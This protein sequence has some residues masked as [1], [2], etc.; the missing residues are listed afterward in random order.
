MNDST[1]Q[2]NQ[3]LKQMLEEATAA[4]AAVPCATNSQEGDTETTSLRE[5]WLAFGQL[6]RVADASLPAMPDIAA[7][8]APQKSRRSRWSRSWWI[9]LVAATAAALLIAVTVGWWSHRDRGAGIQPAAR[10]SVAASPTPTVPVKQERPTTAVSRAEQATNEQAKT[11]P[12]VTFNTV[13]SHTAT[14]KPATSTWEEDPLETQI[15]S[16]SE[17]IRNVEENWRHRVDDADLVRYRIDE[18]TDSLQNDKL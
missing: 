3:R 7:P 8:I 9:G 14:S 17:Q 10:S 11:D 1:N 13:P 4:D 18:V 15:A 12:T 6:I 5:A 16:V 2:D